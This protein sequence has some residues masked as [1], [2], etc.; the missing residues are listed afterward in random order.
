MFEHILCHAPYN[1]GAV[2][3]QLRCCSV[4]QLKTRLMHPRPHPCQCCPLSFPC[5]CLSSPAQSCTHQ[6]PIGR[7]EPQSTTTP[8]TM[9]GTWSGKRTHLRELP[10]LRG[11]LNVDDHARRQ[12]H[13]L[14][15]SELVPV[16]PDGRR[17]GPPMK[18][19]EGTREGH[20]LG[21]LG[22]ACSR[23]ALWRQWH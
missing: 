1:V 7:G 3:R 20:W 4:C 10:V 11:K 19:G 8:L 18:P 2:A 23:P 17:G 21:P 22:V 5:P 13:I 15:L 6:L 16:G 9:A 14:V 12:W